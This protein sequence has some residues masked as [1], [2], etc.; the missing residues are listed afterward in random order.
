MDIHIFCLPYDS[1]HRG[2]RMG[3]GPQY[4]IDA[5]LVDFLEK[6]GHTVSTRMI[7]VQNAFPTEIQTSFDLYRELAVQIQHDCAQ[8]GFPLV[9]SG[10]C[11]A[12]LGGMTGLSKSI[13]RAPGIAW[14]DAHGDFNTPDTTLSGFLDGMGLATLAGLGWKNLARTLPFFKPVETANILHIG[15]RDIDAAEEQLFIEHKVA[16]VQARQVRE[17][18]VSSSLQPL[19][20]DLKTRFQDLYLH[21]DVDV[22]DPVETPANMF[23]TADGL[24]PDQAAEVIGTL[25][26]T[27]NIRGMGVASFDPRYGGK[28]KTLQVVFDLIGSVVG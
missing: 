8:G 22:L 2:E 19:L 15:G 27:F 23:A 28:G 11:G 4:W 6:R 10:N 16:R 1:A 3:A 26:E 21:F 24:F 20:A 7:D 17:N 9:L 12:A 25:R 13:P 14:M 5:G 18:G